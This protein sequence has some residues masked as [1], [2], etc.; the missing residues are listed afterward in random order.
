MITPG[1]KSW[2]LQLIDTTCVASPPAGPAGCHP[3]FFLHLFNLSFK[4]WAPSR[5]CVLHFRAYQCLVVYATSLVLLVAK[6]KSLGSKPE[7]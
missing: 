1:L 5:P 7:V 3:L 2:P 4:I 6:T